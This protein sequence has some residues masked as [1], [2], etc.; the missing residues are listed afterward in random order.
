MAKV[1]APLRA[2]SA[3]ENASW[4][5]SLLGLLLLLALAIGELKVDRHVG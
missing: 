1:L 5:R 4:M 2:I 3:I